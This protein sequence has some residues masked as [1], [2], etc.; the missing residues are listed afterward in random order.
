QDAVEL[1]GQTAAVLGYLRKNAE[2]MDYPTYLAK[3]WLIGS[4][5]VEAAD[6]R[7]S[8]PGATFLPVKVGRRRR[9]CRPRAADL[10]VGEWETEHSMPSVSRVD[11]GRQHSSR[12]RLGV[13]HR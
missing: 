6:H 13:S 10:H 12:T 5:S 3:G 1:D 4:G 9:L 7:R 11:S 8:R 2:R